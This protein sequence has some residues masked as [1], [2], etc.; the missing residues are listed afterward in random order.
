[1]TDPLCIACKGGKDLCGRGY[2]PLLDRIRPKLPLV[3]Y[4]KRE[5]FGSSPPSVFVGRYGYPK[6]RLGPLLPP[7]RVYRADRLDDPAGLWGKEIE[8]V[9]GMRSSLYRTQARPV[10][11]DHVYEPRGM[12]ETSQLLAMSSKPVDTEVL[13]SKRPRPMPP[14]VDFLNRP[15]G[16]SVDA[17]KTRLTENV[18]VPRK[19][20]AVVGDTDLKAVGG[21]VEMYNSGIGDSQIQRLLSIGLLGRKRRRKLV[22]TRW[23][24][25]AVDDALGKGL[26][27]DV[28]MFQELGE[29]EL[30]RGDYAGNYFHII[31]V[32][33]HWSFEMLEKWSKGAF[34]G[35]G[36]APLHDHEGWR[37]RKDYADQITGAYYAARLGAL[38]HL[39][40]RRRQ[41]TVIVNRE[42]TE[43]YWAP[44]GVWVIRETVRNALRGKP[45]KFDTVWKAVDK[46]TAEVRARNWK[47]S[48]VLLKE[49]KVQRR[50][51]DYVD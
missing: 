17:V 15:M 23:S 46:V 49:I 10:K 3:E 14:I 4:D 8:E 6:V 21:M 16:P 12:L 39:V 41:C 44:L 22:P 43:E 30:Y 11:V 38:E 29:V 25:T 50:L 33:R 28:K 36:E 9:I 26:I 20:D 48:S 27:E 45:E 2:C 5:L 13:L 7:M 18:V 31:F 37:G 34:W 1:M 40:R 35:E 32:P 42:I 19:V 51:D 24:I 47:D